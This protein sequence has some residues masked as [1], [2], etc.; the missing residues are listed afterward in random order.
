MYIVYIDMYRYVYIYILS[1]VN[2]YRYRLPGKES[3]C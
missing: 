2:I 1:Y 3:A